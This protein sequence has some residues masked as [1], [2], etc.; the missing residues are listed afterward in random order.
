MKNYIYLQLFALLLMTSCSSEFTTPPPVAPPP[1][2]EELII[3]ELATFVNTDGGTR[4]HYVEIYNGTVNDIDL[5]NYAIGY[6]ASTDA[7]TLEDWNFSA[8]ENYLQFTGT[9]T[10][11]DAYVIASPQANT[12]AVSSDVTWGTTSTAAA[13]SSKPLQLSGN[14]AIAL[15][16]KDAAGTHVLNGENYTIIDV[17]GSPNVARVTSTGSSSSRNNFIW[18]TSGVTDTRNRTFWRKKTVVNP[19]TDWDLSRGTSAIDSEW[20]VSEDKMWDYSNVGIFTN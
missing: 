14:S 4:N 16:K 6:Q 20:N 17:F 10:S 15:L 8:V 1:V 18:I 5:S 2:L 19:N 13:D 11:M 7:S 9:L 3:S 12:A